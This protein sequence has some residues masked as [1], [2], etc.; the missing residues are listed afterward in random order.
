KLS[1]D[2]SA[3]VYS[4]FLG[5]ADYDEA[6]AIAVDEAGQAYV[7]GSGSIPGSVPLPPTSPDP[8]GP[9]VA[10]VAADG[11]SLA[12]AA[13]LAGAAEAFPGGIAVDTASGVYVDR[14]STRLNSSH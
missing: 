14:K 11:S 10:K 1:P 7:T 8:H 3:L 6:R 12:Y 4:T 5:G 9:F 13:F 2:G